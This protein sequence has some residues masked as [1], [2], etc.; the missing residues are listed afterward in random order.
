ML[1]RTIWLHRYAISWSPLWIWLLLSLLKLQGYHLILLELCMPSFM[2]R[3]C[4]RK[5]SIWMFFSLY[6]LFSLI[7]LLRLS[8]LRIYKRCH[9]LQR[10][11]MGLLI[12]TQR[13]QWR[14][15]CLKII[16]ILS[17]KLKFLM[18]WLLEGLHHMI[19]CRLHLD[20]LLRNWLFHLMRFLLP[21]LVAWLMNLLT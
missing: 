20:P 13:L 6:K 8:P 21:G 1:F 3:L 12:L 17:C 4:K 16:V 10:W 15:W 18:I 11:L 5:R 19:R 2:L 14:L 9:V 7:R